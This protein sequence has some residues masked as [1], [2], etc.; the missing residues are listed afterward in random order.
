MKKIIK[1]AFGVMLLTYTTLA[2][3]IINAKTATELTIKSTN[4]LKTKLLNSENGKKA[5]E[6]LTK[7]VNDGITKIANGGFYN[8]FNLNEISTK[9]VKKLDKLLPKDAEYDLLKSIVENELTKKGYRVQ[10]GK[11]DYS[12]SLHFFISWSK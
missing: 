11:Y 6:L 3:E 1:L 8:S 12:G 9:E 10:R 5:Y 2:S 4:D 7:L